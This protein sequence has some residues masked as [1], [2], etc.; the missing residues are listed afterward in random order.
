[1]RQAVEATASK[2]AGQI[3]VSC[4]GAAPT[5]VRVVFLDAVRLGLEATRTAALQDHRP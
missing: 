5:K 1:M 4:H 3:G 2:K